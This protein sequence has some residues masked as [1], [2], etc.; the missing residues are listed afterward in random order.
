MISVRSNILDLPPVCFMVPETGSQYYDWTPHIPFLS[1]L[2]YHLAPRRFVE[3]GVLDGN[4]YLAACQA[5]KLIGLDTECYAIDPWEGT[6]Y[7]LETPYSA[8]YYTS[9]F[10][11][12]A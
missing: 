1:W 3:I 5:I 2:I 12:N 9:F 8:D 7:S 11:R 4:S 6:G 10:N